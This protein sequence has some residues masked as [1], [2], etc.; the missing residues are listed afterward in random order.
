MS[1][2]ADLG[3]RHVY[4]LMLEN[5][6][7]DHM[8]GFSGITGTDADTGTSTAIRGLTGNESNAH[9]GQTFQVQ[10]GAKLSM[11]TD[12]GHEFPEVLQQLCGT[13]AQYPRGGAYPAIDNSGFVDSYVAAGGVSPQEIMNCYT[14]AQLPVLNA[15]AREFVV[16]DNWHASLPGPTWPNRM[17]IH[18]ATSGGLDHSPS[19]FEIAQWEAVA[20]FHFDNGTVFDRLQRHGIR[21]RIYSGDDF[22]MVAALKGIGIGDV[23]HY[24]LFAG[25]IAAANYADQYI[26]IEPSYDVFHQYRDGTSQHPLGDVTKGEALIKQT[27]E[28]IRN[29]P[30]WESSLLIVTWDEH[31]GFYD[32]M[33]PGA[34]TPPGDTGLDSQHNQNG[35]TFRQYGVR[36]PAVVISPRVPKGLID[37]RLYDHASIS[38]TLAMLFDMNP[39]TG[40]DSNANHLDS[41]ITL[42]AARTDAPERLPAAAT[43]ALTMT[44][45]VETVN[46]QA[47]ANSGNIPA[48]VH[49]AMQQDIA[50][51]PQF[52]QQ[53]AARVQTIQTREDARQYLREVRDK[54]RPLRADAAAR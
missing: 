14:P 7:F 18:A 16:C 19:V 9:N 4:V 40:R 25:D 46:P 45:T 50:A 1:L 32:H 10:R 52:R 37:H 8:L 27:Y 51:T 47:S 22:P 35:F 42:K 24:D 3:I 2:A 41:L 6:S 49:A 48:I 36:V 33:P 43:P 26:F 23:R 15:L 20:G 21:R 30:A 11:P 53:I 38:A 31:G 29:S 5:R 54:V 17:F 28:A 12:P 39:L 44:A 34:A 13:G